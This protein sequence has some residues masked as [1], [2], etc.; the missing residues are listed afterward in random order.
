VHAAGVVDGKR[1]AD[2]DLPGS[3]VLEDVADWLA[4]PD[5]IG[6]G[7]RRRQNLADLLIADVGPRELDAQG[8][9]LGDPGPEVGGVDRAV[10]IR[11]WNAP[12]PVE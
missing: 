3:D 2:A 1:D 9:R 4:R 12:D 11:A 8:A 10:L 5:A 7:G 6:A